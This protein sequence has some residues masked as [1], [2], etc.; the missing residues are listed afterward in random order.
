M[1]RIK[2]YNNITLSLGLIFVLYGLVRTLHEWI[3][4]QAVHMNHAVNFLIIGLVI[5]FLYVVLNAHRK[6]LKELQMQIW[7]LKMLNKKNKEKQG[8]NQLD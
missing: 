5:C 6:F 7:T 1:E 4:Y 8:T 2:I 3:K